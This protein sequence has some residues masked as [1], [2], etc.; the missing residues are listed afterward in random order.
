MQAEWF[1]F[2]NPDAKQERTVRVQFHRGEEPLEG[3]NVKVVCT[4]H[5][6]DLLPVVLNALSAKYGHNVSIKVVRMT[7]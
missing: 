1:P 5:E 3:V 4:G 7:P 2:P 6:A